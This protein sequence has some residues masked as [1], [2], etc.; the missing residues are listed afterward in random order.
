MKFP[1]RTEPFVAD[2][3]KLSEAIPP[4]LV[5]RDKKASIQYRALLQAAPDAIV[6][7][8]PSGVIVLVNAQTERL[9]GYRR[10]ELIG[11]PAEMLVAEQFRSQHSDQHSR[12]VTLAP[13]RTAVAGLDLFG[14]RK[15]GS[16]FPA[17]VR[18]SPLDT[19]QG[20]LVSSA[21]RDISDRRRTEEDLRRLASIVTCSDDAIVGKTLEGIITS[22]NAGAER[23][24]GYSAKEAIGQSVAMLVPVSRP[25]EVFGILERLKRGEV[26]D[27]FE[28]TRLRRDG[29]EFHI[30][31][32]ASPIRDSMERI[33]GASTIGR[34]ISARKAAEKQLLQ[35]DA[36]LLQA[37]KMEAVGQLAGGV[38]HDFNNLLGVILGYAELLLERPGLSD[39]QRK[40]IEEIQKAGERAALLTRQLLAFSRKQV[41]QPKVIDLNALL[42]VTEKLLQR[43]IGEQIELRVIR[44][45][46]MC[47]I[48]VDPGQIEQVVMNLALNARDAMPAGGKLTI[49]TSSVELNEEHASR[50]PGTQPG[51]HVMLTVTDTGSGMDAATTDRI[52]DPFFTTKPLGKGTGLGLTIVAGIVKQSGG[53]VSVQ[54]E[55]GLGTTFHIWL[56]CVDQIPDV[57]PPLGEE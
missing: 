17:E 20:T 14:L 7:V 31:I 4:L 28:T 27:H 37:Q 16:E 52:F 48:K 44:C 12:F 25:D 22:W 26:V 40:D 49:A 41:L 13:T 53:S 5:R 46:E 33:V 1:V 39:A 50:H 18:L 54:S 9:F 47:R 6:V 57:G 36:M 3:R 35:M 55:L 43:L 30:E 19:K 51:S 32:T 10:D 11:Q 45:P 56:P 38:A 8:N 34:D 23:I 21:I 2:V 24:Y 42:A 15:D 29:K